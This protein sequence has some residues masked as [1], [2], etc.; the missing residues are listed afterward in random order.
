MENKPAKA[1]RREFASCAA[2]AA[3][4]FLMTACGPRRLHEVPR[5]RLQR[6]VRDMEREYSQKYGEEVT[7]SDAGPLAKKD[8]KTQSEI[9]ACNEHTRSPPIGSRP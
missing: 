9:A 1:T 6:L 4:G 5:E 3:A 7:V 2:A 8:Q